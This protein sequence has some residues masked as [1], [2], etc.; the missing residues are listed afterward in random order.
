M[1]WLST[2]LSLLFGGSS[3]GL[4][5][6]LA[7]ASDHDDAEERSHDGRTEQD[8]D[9]GN[10]DSPDARREDGVKRVIGIDEGL[11]EVSTAIGMY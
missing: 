5:G 6:P 7:V 11:Q 10:A 4:R 2:R 1:P 9:N 8:Q 3:L